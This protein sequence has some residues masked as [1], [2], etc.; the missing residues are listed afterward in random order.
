MTYTFRL[1]GNCQDYV[2]IN[3]EAD[4]VTEA[5]HEAKLQAKKVKSATSIRHGQG[6]YSL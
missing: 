2:V 1:H 4:S 6:I 3:I 5:Y